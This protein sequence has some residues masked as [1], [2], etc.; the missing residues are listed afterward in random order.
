MRNEQVIDRLKGEGF[1]I[2]KQRKLIVDVIMKNDYTSCKDI[3]YQV[4]AKDN[5]VGMATVYRMIRVL[6]DIGVIRRI[7]MIEINKDIKKE[8]DNMS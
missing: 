6:E 7:D 1:R 5:S 3:Y 8:I 4:M 2:T